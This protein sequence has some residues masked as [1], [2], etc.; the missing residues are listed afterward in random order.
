V[1]GRKREVVS[2]LSRVSQFAMRDEAVVAATHGFGP[3]LDGCREWLVDALESLFGGGA[4]AGIRHMAKAVERVPGIHF[5]MGLVAQECVFQGGA[6][7]SGI[8]L[9][10]LAEFVAS[11]LALAGLE[12]GVSEVLVDRS[13]SRSHLDR[14]LEEDDSFVILPRLETAVGYRERLVGRIRLLSHRRTKRHKQNAKP[15]QIYL[16][17]V[18]GGISPKSRISLQ[19][20]IYVGNWICYSQRRGGDADGCSG[21]LFFEA[22]R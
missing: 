7:V 6:I 5:P 9:K 12:V 22:G 8:E 19:K 21:A 4:N 17:S 14:L 11:S 20:R 16:V 3:A 13:A 18:N 15:H 2:L 1:L 10:G